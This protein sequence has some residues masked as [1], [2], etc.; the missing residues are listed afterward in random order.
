MA[1]AFLNACR[2]CPAVPIDVEDS[3]QP[4]RLFLLAII[5]LTSAA[6]AGCAGWNPNQA[7]EERAQVAQTIA[8]FKR[9]DPGL[10]SFFQHAYGYA[11]FPTVGKG[12]IGVGGAYGNGRVFERDRFIGRASLT[13]V[14][15]GFQFGGQAY[16]EIIFF[17]DRAALARFKSGNLKFAAQA[18][19]VAVTAGAAANAA[20]ERGVAVF[21]M[22]KGGLMYE[23]TIG[24]QSFSFEPR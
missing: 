20:Y 13:Q 23:A 21:T 19:A 5:S 8:K 10:R 9:K 24:G 11:V 3:M 18:S 17:K 14:T 16:S 4:R 2:Q 1:Y 6:L 12:G 15:V 22:E 7:R